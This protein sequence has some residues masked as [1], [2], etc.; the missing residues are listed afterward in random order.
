MVL[1]FIKKFNLFFNLSNNLEIQSLF[2]C[3]IGRNAQTTILFDLGLVP[4]SILLIY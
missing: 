4:R 2:I 1:V 3:T